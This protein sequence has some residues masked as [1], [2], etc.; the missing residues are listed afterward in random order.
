MHENTQNTIK[1]I[2]K[3]EIDRAPPTAESEECQS[4]TS[5]TENNIKK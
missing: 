3:E 2:Q 5:K 1:K 4:N